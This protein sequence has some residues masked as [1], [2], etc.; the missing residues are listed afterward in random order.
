MLYGY[1]TIVKV[2]KSFIIEKLLT[3][4]FIQLRCKHNFVYR[5]IIMHDLSA[6]HDCLIHIR[7]FIETHAK[8]STYIMSHTIYFITNFSNNESFFLSET[9][10]IINFLTTIK[11]F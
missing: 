6:I 4:L 2:K 1:Y 9:N 3:N 11:Q 7:K 5:C 8:K 10:S